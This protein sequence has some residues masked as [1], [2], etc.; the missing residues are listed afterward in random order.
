VAW[1]S[2]TLRGELGRFWPRAM[3]AVTGK[4]VE[5]LRLALTEFQT[6]ADE[7]VIFK[8]NLP[9]SRAVEFCLRSSDLGV[10]VQAHAGNGIVIGKLP[11]AAATLEKAEAIVA[12]LR[13]LAREGGGNLVIF[14]CPAEWKRALRVFGE[15]EPAWPLAERVKSALDPCDLLNRGR[16]AGPVGR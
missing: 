7:P 16:F 11:D 9:P 4:S 6:C 5:P 2:D 10:A 15:P 13:R 3:E 14:D 8:A 12:A 1:Q